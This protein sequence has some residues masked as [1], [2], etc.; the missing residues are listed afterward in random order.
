MTEEA[1]SAA[2]EAVAAEAEVAAAEAEASA[3]DQ[4]KC[5]KQ[6]VL[7]VNK[8]QKYLSYHLATD[9]FIAEN[10]TPSTNQRDIK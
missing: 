2:A 6:L 9:L 3:A 10:A 4:E 7:I 8:K 1:V 5:T